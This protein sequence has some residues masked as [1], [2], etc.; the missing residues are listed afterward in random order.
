MLRD[1]SDA[2]TRENVRTVLDGLKAD[3]SNGIEEVL[4]HDAIVRLGGFPQA[5][6]LVTFKIG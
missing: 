2:A 1:P 6:F 4:D 5:S 3:S